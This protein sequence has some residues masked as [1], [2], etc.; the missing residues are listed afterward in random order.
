MRLEQRGDTQ[1]SDV[2]EPAARLSLE[3]ETVPDTVL[4]YFVYLFISSLDGS[5]LSPSTAVKIPVQLSV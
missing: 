3:A 1:P 5:T 2:R 4:E